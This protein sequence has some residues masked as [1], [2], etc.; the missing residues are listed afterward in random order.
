MYC[1]GS[2][3]CEAYL[4]KIQHWAVLAKSFHLLSLK[5]CNNQPGLGGSSEYMGHMA[6]KAY[7]ANT[8]GKKESE[9]WYSTCIYTPPFCLPVPLINLPQDT[10]ALLIA[11]CAL[12]RS[13]GQ[14]VSCIP[15]KLLPSLPYRASTPFL[16]TE[17]TSSL[18]FYRPHPRAPHIAAQH[19]HVPFS[20]IFFLRL[21]TG[22]VFW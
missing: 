11:I 13:P 20:S 2:R 18:P 15:Y 6:R 9:L 12:L 1:C 10:M 3:T 14:T 8:E 21:K 16:L 19:K 22:S 4:F 5:K 7:T 17:F